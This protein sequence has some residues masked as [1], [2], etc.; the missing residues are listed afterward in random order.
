MISEILKTAVD[1]EHFRESL[2]KL[3][4]KF[5]FSVDSMT[6]LGE[7][8][9]KLYPDSVNHGNPA[10]VLI[11]YSIVR[12][13]IIEH[14]LRDMEGSIKML[15]REMFNNISSIDS[16]MAEMVS[17][18]GLE[19]ARRIYMKIDGR[20][21]ELKSDIDSMANSVIKERYTGGI[22]LFYNILYLMKKSLNL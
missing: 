8:Y 4:G 2:V 11:G 22:T 17:I 12:I 10:H 21:R 18:L 3:D 19:E 20:I 16:N 9:C 1:P 13:A 14:I 15:F 6:A 5:D 7:V